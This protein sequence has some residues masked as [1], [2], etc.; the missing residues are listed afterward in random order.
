MS[1]TRTHYWLP[2]RIVPLLVLL[3]LLLPTAAG[4]APQPEYQICDIQF[5]YSSNYGDSILVKRWVTVPAGGIH[6]LTSEELSPN[7]RP[8]GYWCY[9]GPTSNCQYA[10]HYPVIDMNPGD[11][12][13]VCVGASDNNPGCGD[14]LYNHANNRCFVCDY[15]GGSQINCREV[16]NIYGRITEGSNP[17]PNATVT[18]ACS[19]G[20]RTATTNGNGDYSFIYVRSGTCTLTPSKAGYTFNPSSR[21]VSGGPPYLVTDQNFAAIP[22]PSTYSISGRVVDGNGAPIANVAVSDGAGHTA[23]TNGNGDYTLSN[24]PAGSYTVTPSK[25]GYAFVPASRSVAVP[26][27][28]T[29]QNFT[30]TPVPPPPSCEVPYYSQIDPRWKNHSLRTCSPCGYNPCCSC[31]CNTIGRCGCTLTSATMV[32]GWY[33]STHTPASLSDCMGTAACPFYWSVGARCSQ[34]KATWVGRYGFT[35]DRLQTELNQNH[36]PVILG[37]HR[38]DNTHWVVVLS[39]SGSNRRNYVIHDPGVRNGAYMRLSAYKDWTLDWISV[40]QGRSPCQGI[41]IVTPVLPPASPL[42]PATNPAAIPPEA[43]L[44][45]AEAQTLPASAVITGSIAPYRMTDVTMTI[46]LAA[47]SSVGDI[48]EMLVWTNSMTQTAWQPFRYL[49]YLPVSEQMYAIFRDTAGNISGIVSNTL[50]PPYSPGDA[51]FELYLPLIFR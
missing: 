30:G 34:G 40:Y 9:P 32:L 23:T 20:S 43:F 47:S 28:A 19:D 38:G 16:F 13:K 29:G 49:V 24:L 46:E 17:L 3:A 39:G 25:G 4:S 8:L 21:T 5:W 31:Y 7:P 37:M 35:W 33:G 15:P 41:E 10:A 11:V 14:H 44:T 45:V 1:D 27:N 51:P 50:F 6:W 48:T 42:L 26:P 36:R 22:N 18:A 2:I 12:V